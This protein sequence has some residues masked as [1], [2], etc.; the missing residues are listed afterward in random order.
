MSAALEVGHAAL[1]ERPPN[2]VLALSQYEE[3]LAIAAT[4]DDRPSR[5]ECLRAVASRL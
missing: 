1:D 3:A 4:A 2:Y 5:G